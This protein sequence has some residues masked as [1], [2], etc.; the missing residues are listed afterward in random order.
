VM[1]YSSLPF[2]LSLKKTFSYHHHPLH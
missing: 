2:P 1:L